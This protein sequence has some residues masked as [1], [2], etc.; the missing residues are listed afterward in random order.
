M[1]LL[2]PKGEISYPLLDLTPPSLPDLPSSHIPLLHQA[3]LLPIDTDDRR[4]LNSKTST[5]ALKARPFQVTTEC[6]Q[7]RSFTTGR[8][9]NARPS[10]TDPT[11]STTL[12]L[13]HLWMT[14]SCLRSRPWMTLSDRGGVACGVL[15]RR[16]RRGLLRKTRSSLI[17]SESYPIPPC[18]RA[19][20]ALRALF[21]AAAATRAHHRLPTAMSRPPLETPLPW[22]RTK[23]HLSR[24]TPSWLIS[25]LEAHLPMPSS[26][27]PIPLL[28]LGLP[29]WPTMSLTT[30]HR[31]TQQLTTRQA[32][33]T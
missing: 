20:A 19:T 27:Q 18:I 22:H 28:S 8:T 21:Q 13:A 33:V 5:V 6:L 12:C 24:I 31:P 32:R 23:A 29:P 7:R 16:S 11:A 25:H 9:R 1:I 17:P 14:C 10:S 3:R 15:S 4:I 26:A 30:L 2:S